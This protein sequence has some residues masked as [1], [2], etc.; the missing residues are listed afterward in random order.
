MGLPNI[1]GKNKDPTGVLFDWVNSAFF[2]SYVRF[3][4]TLQIIV[5]TRL[6]S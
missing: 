5:V 1:L 4:N 6:I 3:T 2:F